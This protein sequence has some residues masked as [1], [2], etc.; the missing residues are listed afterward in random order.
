MLLEKTKKT[1]TK[2]TTKKEQK[3]EP[4][5]E[6][7]ANQK[8]EPKKEQK[9]VKSKPQSD[10]NDIN[11]CIRK[12]YISV[13]KK[14]Y[15]NFETIPELKDYFNNEKNDPG[16]FYGNSYNKIHTMLI[17]CYY[18]NIDIVNNTVITFKI[19]DLKKNIDA[20]YSFGYYEQIDKK[21]KKNK[22]FDYNIIG[23]NIDIKCYSVGGSYISKDGEYRPCILRPLNIIELRKFPLSKITDEIIDFIHDK[24][25]T[26]NII[27]LKD[28]FFPTD[29]KKTIEPI[30]E[31]HTHDTQYT[32][33]AIAWFSLMMNLKLGI[34][35]NNLNAKFQ[36]ILLGYKEDDLNFFNRIIEKNTEDIINRFWILSNNFAIRAG[37]SNTE[38]TKLG[39]KIIP[40]SISEAQNPFNLRFQ[41][42][43]EYIISIN[44]SDLLINN[45]SPGFFITN[46]WCYIK[47]SRKGLFDNEIQYKKME[48]SEF[49]EQITNLLN[50]ATIYTNE[51]IRPDDNKKR[52]NMV[53]SWLSEKFKILHDK[54]QDPINYAKE[55]IIMSNVALVI[56]TEYVGRTVMDVLSLCKTSKYYDDLIGNPFTINGFPIFCKYMFD[57]CYNIYCI[58]Y[59]L[60][61]IHGDLHL[62]NA[63]IK[64][65][66]FK[67]IRDIK[68]VD[69]PTVMYVLGPSSSD[70]YIFPTAGN[71][72]CLIDFSRSIILPNS[73][74]N[75]TDSSLPK[76]Y[77]LINKRKEF[78]EDQVDRLLYLYFNYTSDSTHNIDNLRI[79]FRNKFEAVFKLLTVT[80][81]YG[82][83]EKLL[84][85]FKIN[86]KLYVKPHKNA[87]E[88]VEKINTISKK[89]ITEEMNKLITNSLYE[90]T[91]NKMEWPIKTIINECF[92]DFLIKEGKI[93]TLTDVFNIDNKIEYSLNKIDKFPETISH[94]KYIKDNKLIEYVPEK[95]KI[96]NNNRKNYEKKKAKGMHVINYIANRQRE[97]HL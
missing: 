54:I 55:E 77:S 19:R 31:Y 70:Q 46:Q 69:S 88:L 11:D 97:K 64:H 49:A 37:N 58:N 26:R 40:L 14:K 56:I 68:E 51:N 72:L 43:K 9:E 45:V 32:L 67:Y 42:W 23:S 22:N 7:N 76:S 84:T 38:I 89:F 28:Y 71:N 12:Y 78:H 33:L 52:N 20:I 5:K 44:L 15:L 13:Y 41:P 36:E 90:D 18:L 75:L 83:T 95:S 94:T 92:S 24:F 16:F 17:F 6:S 62:N 60:G 35:E 59:R 21:N 4:K 73:I 53:D 8:K 27:L 57:L 25:S 50:R 82:F 93:G 74:D 81:I 1:E 2:T 61:I 91:I 29:E 10:P 30:L 48:R 80:D 65:T 96:K 87:I 3:K 34:I 63:T 85:L 79:I 39:Q 66:S 47:N 86:S